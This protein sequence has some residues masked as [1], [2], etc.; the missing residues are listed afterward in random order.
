MNFIPYGISF[1]TA[2]AIAISFNQNTSVLWA[3]IH[4]FFGWFYVVY[5]ILLK[6]RIITPPH[7]HVTIK[8]P[9]DRF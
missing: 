6:R 8:D 2:L 4:G 3:M 7:I 5:Y 1:G 9:K